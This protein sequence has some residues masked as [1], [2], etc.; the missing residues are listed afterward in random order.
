MTDSAELQRLTGAEQAAIVMLAL[1]RDHG[2][3]LWPLLGDEEVLQ[4]SGV[5]AGLGRISRE[6]ADTLLER[7]GQ[8]LAG[9]PAM[10][11]GSA[12][13]A[14]RLLADLLPGER[15]ASLLKE[16]NGNGGV[17]T[18]E[19]LAKVDETVLAGFLAGEHPQTVAVVLS[20]LRPDQSGRVLAL[21]PDPLGRE[22]IACML[23]AEPV[24]REA[25]AQLERTLSAEFDRATGR[26]ARRDPHAALAELFNAM[27]QSAEQRLMGDLETRDAAAAER[28]RALM[29]TFE[30]LARLPG[31]AMQLL[32]ARCDKAELPRAI[33]GAPEAL[34][35]L[36]FANMSERSARLLREEIEAM[37]G[38][39]RRD[40]ERARANLVRLAK[41]LADAGEIDLG[42]GSDDEA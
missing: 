13:A 18:W 32:L 15:A 26:S 17:S 38:L 22:V 2:A 8:A 39:R 21:L 16:L 29:F 30:D 6:T 5:M 31:R 35:T 20:H 10:L 40:S 33:R 42:D 34:Q 1:G 25:L 28:I 11:Q 41:S 7:F 36:V 14:Q 4:L 23:S 27:D 12:T 9:N 19:R 24:Q 3:P 37:T